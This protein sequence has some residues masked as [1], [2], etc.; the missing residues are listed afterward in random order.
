MYACCTRRRSP[1]SYLSRSPLFPRKMFLLA[2][3]RVRLLYTSLKSLFVFIAFSVISSQVMRFC[4]PREKAFFYKPR[5]PLFPRKLCLFAFPRVRLLYTSSKSLFVFIA[6]SV[7]STQAVLVRFLLVYACCTLRKRACGVLS[8]LIA[9]F[10]VCRVCLFF[11]VILA[12]KGRETH[13][14]ITG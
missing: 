8:S 6:F 3:P 2:F 12:P 5:S 11:S 7:I 9:I 4:A 13:L 10:C 1:S 14:V